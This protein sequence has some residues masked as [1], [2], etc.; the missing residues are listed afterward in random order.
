M[1]RIELPPGLETQLD[2]GKVGKLVDRRAGRSRVVWAFC[3]VLA[4]SRLPYIEFV[5]TQDQVSFTG[6]VVSMLV[7]CK[8]EFPRIAEKIPQAPGGEFC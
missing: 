5:W 7:F 4:H 1:I 2:Y 3:G 8:P 6:S